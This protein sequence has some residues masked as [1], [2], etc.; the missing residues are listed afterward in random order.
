MLSTAGGTQHNISNLSKIVKNLVEGLTLPGTGN[1]PFFSFELIHFHFNFHFRFRL[2]CI[3]PIKPPHHPPHP[4]TKGAVSPERTS[5]RL[6]EICPTT[7][8]TRLLERIARTTTHDSPP[9]HK[10]DHPTL[11]VRIHLLCN[12]PPHQPPPI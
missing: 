5:L 4:T 10:V 11:M 1:P 6:K 7:C 8:M 9:L 3:P 2:I 12:R